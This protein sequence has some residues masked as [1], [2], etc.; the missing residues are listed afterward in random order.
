MYMTKQR[1][2]LTTMTLAFYSSSGPTAVARSCMHLL[3]RVLIFFLHPYSVVGTRDPHRKGSYRIERSLQIL[4]ILI[5]IQYLFVSQIKDE[6]PGY[7]FLPLKDARRRDIL[8]VLAHS[9]L[10]FFFF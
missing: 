9:S 1:A 5:S 2:S 10:P 3:M 8:A 6:L 4:G 7:F